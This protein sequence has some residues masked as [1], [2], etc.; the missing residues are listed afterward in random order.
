VTD[1]ISPSGYIMSLSKKGKGFWWN[2]KKRFLIE[3]LYS[4]IGLTLLALLAGI[5]AVGV[6]KFGVIFG[7]LILGMTI[8]LPSIYCIV[9]FPRF[10]I[11]VLIVVAYLL[12]YFGRLGIEGPMGVVADGIQAMLILGTLWR[13]RRH[14]DW[15]ILKGPVSTIIL[16]W[17][18]YN[19][20]QLGNPSAVSRLAWLYTIRSVAI[21]MF[22][23][24]VFVYHIRSIKYVR[25]IFKIWLALSLYAAL[26]GMK[27]EYIGFSAAED[28]YLHSDPEIAGLLFIAG[29]WRKFSIFS[30]PVAFAYNMS[31]AATF[32]IALIAGK[33]PGWKKTI[34]AILTV[35]FLV[36]MLF[37][38]TRGAYVLVPAALFLFAILNYNKKVLIYT[39]VAAVFFVVLINVPTGDPNLLRFQTAFKPNDDPSYKLRKYNQK[40]IQPYIL[41]HPI[42]FGLGAVGG[43]GKRFGD[44]GLVS[45]FQPDS[46]YI[47]TAVELG[48]VGLIIFCIMMFIVMKTGINNFYRAKDPE[49]KTYILGI[50]MVIFAYN[51]ANFPQE[52]LVQFPSNVLFSLDMAM[53]TILYRLDKQNQEELAI[54]TTTQI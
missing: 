5:I 38:G 36:A 31:M 1:P 53:L 14:N 6:A 4:P 45:Q 32:C 2:F 8:G 41:T 29:H 23:Y 50:T 9:A 11:I 28:A 39:C 12:F 54:Q 3:K 34:L 42:G 24:F 46:G 52:A 7:A 17:I 19:I 16:I 33:F 15:D 37:S 40:R 35:M 48:P 22:S 27:Q 10:G 49:I 43:W 25:L 20:L 44:G 26:Y 18:G 47:R 13:L 21:V 51:I 30:D